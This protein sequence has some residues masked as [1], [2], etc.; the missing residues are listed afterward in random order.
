MAAV[1]AAADEDEDDDND[2]DNENR[3]VERVVE[4]MMRG[5]EIF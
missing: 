3:E 4:P 1:N 5:K 2:G